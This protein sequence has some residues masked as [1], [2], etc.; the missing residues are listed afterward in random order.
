MSSG[1]KIT[2][3]FEGNSLFDVTIDKGTLNA[4]VQNKRAIRANGGQ[5][6][7]TAEGGDQVLSAQVNN[8]GIVQAR[9]VSALRGGG[10]TG[11]VKIGKIRMI[12]DGGTTNVSGKLDA[13][14]PKGGDGGFIETSGNKVNIAD[15]VIITTKAAAGKNGT[16][17][18]DPYNIIISNDP[19]ANGSFDGGTPNSYTATGP[20]V[21]NVAMLQTALASNNVVI[22]TD[23][24][25]SPG[26]DVGNIDVNAAVTWSASTTLTLNAA[27]NININKAITA[28]G[29]TAGLTLNAGRD[30]NINNAVTFSGA[31][32]KLEMNYG[33]YN[34]AT[35]TT[36]LAGT[37]YNI[38]TKASYS[39][40]VLDVNGLPVAQVDPHDPVN[41]G[42][43]IYGSINLTNIANTIGTNPDG[44]KINGQ[45]YTMIH[46]MAE[47][48][49]LSAVNLDAGGEP[50]WIQDPVTFL[51]TL[52]I[53]GVADGHYAL[54]QD[55]NASG[56]TYSYSI[57]NTLS[58]TLAGLGHK[59]SDLSMSS[60]SNWSNLAL[61]GEAGV[62]SV[63]RDIGILNADISTGGNSVGALVG[64][65]LGDISHA[66]STGRVSGGSN[67]GGLIGY[68][69]TYPNPGVYNAI[70]DSFSDAIVTGNSSGGLIGRTEYANIHRSHATG[71]VTSSN[72]SIGGLIG[73]ASDTNI[74]DSYATGDV[75]GGTGQYAYAMGGLVGSVGNGTGPLKIE[76]SFTSGNVSGGYQIGGL[77][78]MLSSELADFTIENSHATGNITG[79]QNTAPVG[80]SGVGGLVGTAKAGAH[81]KIVIRNSSA[82]GDVKSAG[83]LG[84]GVG[85]LVGYMLNKGVIENS[86]ATGNVS[87][88]AG[89]YGVGGLVGTGSA[90]DVSDSYATGNVTGY[91]TV[92]GLVGGNSGT[93]S[94]SYA[95][96]NV[97]GSTINVGGLVGTNAHSGSIT[98]SHAT[99]SVT[100]LGDSVFRDGG[101]GG[102]VGTN[103]GSIINSY[104]TGFVTGPSGL[105]GGIAGVSFNNSGSGDPADTTSGSITNSWYS[106][107]TN[108]GLPITNSVPGLK[109]GVV[110]GGGG[111]TNRQMADVQYYA[112]GTINQVLAG[113][114]FQADA[115][116]T[117][118]AI[119]TETQTASTTPPDTSMS[120]AGDKAASTAKSDALNDDAKAIDEKIKK[121]EDAERERR[122]KAVAASNPAQS[123][124]GNG[125]G[126]GAT[127]R[128]IDV[129]GKRF[130]LEGGAG[131]DGG[132]GNNNNDGGAP[133]P[134]GTAQ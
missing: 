36:P 78:G 29:D 24:A 26:A 13:S 34:G 4:L 104:A 31:N 89:G 93:I 105:T 49:A 69:G 88:S 128:S 75:T 7:M 109:V 53:T 61:V 14:A 43:G 20:S 87:G 79:N 72:G 39:G 99:G 50:I 9:S 47:L 41:G 91:S 74:F 100:G 15:N 113:R 126:L 118:S 35:V 70:S 66:Y 107:E 122:R 76:N 111:L 77:V 42:D 64:S 73:A 5:V 52:S 124:S 2:L 48:A 97:F 44:L 85:G 94:N 46:S 101:T 3:N 30:I 81:S 62:G 19:T 110:N 56:T 25:G 117:G 102:L 65:N 27:N 51:Y 21:V 12:A 133:A 40:A 129:D 134:G 58:G 98:G 106:S 63:I 86:H 95:T 8:T 82:T 37:N 130:D 92:G 116:R 16:W 38:L 18:L 22:S 60:N 123:G 131:K 6:I 112:N 121:A 80:E 11:G 127:I 32:A 115:A 83:S 55:L 119:A 28:D 67:V 10:N 96:G 120:K 33:G 103:A 71:N 108:S 84:D 17:L 45:A 54:A 90:T 132:A 114:A 1:E 23:V 68:N 125:S 59:V 57:I